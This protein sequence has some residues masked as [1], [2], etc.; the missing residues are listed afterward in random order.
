M[1]GAFGEYLMDVLNWVCVSAVLSLVMSIIL[2]LFVHFRRRGVWA[3]R[4]TG[5]S[6]LMTHQPVSKQ[7]VTNDVAAD[8]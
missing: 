6:G 7:P 8:A 2:D 5:S 4:G 3:E 1:E